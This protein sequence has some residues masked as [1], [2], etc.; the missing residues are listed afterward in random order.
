MFISIFILVHIEKGSKSIKIPTSDCLKFHRH[1]NKLLSSRIIYPF[2][3]LLLEKY[4][5]FHQER[6]GL[7]Y[8]CRERRV[9]LI[10]NR[11]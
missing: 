10:E 5:Q 2:V 9:V 6:L 11:T 4:F 7:F 3:L 1:F 8:K